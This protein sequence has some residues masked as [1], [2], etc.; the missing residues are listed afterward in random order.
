MTGPSWS[1]ATRSA[2]QKGGAVMARL[3][4]FAC[5]LAVSVVWSGLARADAAS[6]TV[7]PAT[8]GNGVPLVFGHAAFDLADVG[9]ERSEFFVEGTASA[10]TPVNPL[11]SNGLWTVAPSSSAAYKTRIVV[12]RPINA[13]DF[14]G[15]VVV[16]WFNVSGGADASPDWQHM[17]VELVR[18][19]H[20]WV[21]VSAQ[22]VGLNQLKC[23]APGVGCPAAGDPGRYG[24]LVHPTDSYSYD[25]FS[26]A[27]QA[28][29]DNP[30]LVLG[31]LVPDHL[32][33]AG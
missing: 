16:E 28:I 21:G 6:P 8:G 12:N 31:G 3:L 19:G 4:S 27:G 23:A 11:T 22:A 15:T 24:S 17:H 20:V 7:T 5:A 26:Q 33:A 9:Y 14:S 29:R 32:V 1:R 10:Y 2:D 18:A 13:A 30:A 25:I